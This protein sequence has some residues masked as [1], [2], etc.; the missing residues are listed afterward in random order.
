MSCQKLAVYALIICVVLLSGCK[1]GKPVAEN[2]A[3]IDLMQGTWKGAEVGREGEWILII[4]GE[5]ITVDGPGPEDY[6]G[7][8]ALDE[9]TTPKSVVLTI[10]ECGFEQYIGA[11]ANNLYKIEDGKLTIAG[12]E[13]GSGMIPSSFEPGNGTRVF[14][15]TKADVQQ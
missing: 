3:D 10:D 12:T 13:P 9:T 5:K 7:T 11:K 6:V 2:D 14:E 4:A 1:K 8:L 15:L